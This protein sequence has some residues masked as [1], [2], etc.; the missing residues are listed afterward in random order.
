[1]GLAVLKEACDEILRIAGRA[2]VTETD[3]RDLVAMRIGA[4]PAAV[5]A[6]E[7]TAAEPIWKAGAV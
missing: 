3:E 7:R 1:M 6:Y 4:V 5:L 2:R